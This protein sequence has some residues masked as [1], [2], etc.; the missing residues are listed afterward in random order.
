MMF[1]Y[2]SDTFSFNTLSSS[3]CQRGFL[4]LVV[5]DKPSPIDINDNVKLKCIY[6]NINLGNMNKLITLINVFDKIS[7]IIV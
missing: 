4:N 6:S 3:C 1:I 7:T 5:N 2:C